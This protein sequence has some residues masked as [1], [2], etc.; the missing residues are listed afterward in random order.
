MKENPRWPQDD[1]RACFAYCASCK[2]EHELRVG[3]ARRVA[4]ILCSQLE[5]SGRMDFE[6]TQAHPDFSL[7][8]L[9]GSARGQMLGV[10]S[11]EDAAGKRGWAKAFSGQYN[12]HWEIPGWVPPVLDPESFWGISAPVDAQIKAVSRVLRNEGSEEDC[13]LAKKLVGWPLTTERKTELA[14]YRKRLSQELMHDIQDLYVLRNFRG[15]ESLLR[16]VFLAKGIPTGAGDCC[17][18]KLLQYAVKHKL[19]PLGLCEFYWGREN[20]SGSRQHGH[21]YAACKEK[22]QPLLGFMLCG[23]GDD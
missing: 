13:V 23:L 6:S 7:E 21:F 2:V 3:P 4:Q 15:E 16:D 9:W 1:F 18:P 5:T 22:C 8:Y 10:M 20:R 14:A 19:R 11:Y 12:G 17:A